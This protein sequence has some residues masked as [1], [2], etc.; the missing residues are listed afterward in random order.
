MNSARSKKLLVVV[1]AVIFAG[2]I[3]WYVLDRSFI[4][5]K[6][7]LLTA[8]EGEQASIKKYRTA[9]NRD[10]AIQRALSDYGS[11]TLGGDI[12]T[13]DHELRARLNQIG[14]SSQL[15]GVR[16]D[17]GRYVA[18]K[19]PAK[20]LFSGKMSDEID[21]VELEASISAEGALSEVVEMIDRIDAEA[22]PKQINQV[23]LDPKGD[24]ETVKVVVRLTTLF[25]PGRPPGTLMKTN[26]AADRLARVEPLIEGNP[27]RLPL[28]PP[29]PV[30]VVAAPAPRMFPYQNWALTG[31]IESPMIEAHIRN[32]ASG[33]SRVLAVGDRI[34]KMEFVGVNGLVAEFDF[35][36]ELWFVELGATMVDRQVLP[37]AERI[38]SA[39]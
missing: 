37:E 20:R 16:V 4:T 28:P 33:K 34:H 31:V 30:A 5:P 29:S 27:F 22:W 3:I 2:A 21:F 24:G 12:E 32:S 19:S 13:V 26:W 1:I 17:T 15:A 9:L 23:S 18:L 6:Q 39:Q 7:E 10:P 11:R 35:E 14:Q 36:G 8:I 38:G 25:V